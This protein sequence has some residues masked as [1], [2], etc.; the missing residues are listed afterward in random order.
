MEN[1]DQLVRQKSAEGVNS[2][3]RKLGEISFNAQAPVSK[4]ALQASQPPHPL[5][6]QTAPQLTAHLPVGS[7]AA[8][9]GGHLA[10]PRH[11]FGVSRSNSASSN[12]SRQLN[13]VSSLSSIPETT[14]A[15][16]T[17]QLQ[18]RTKAVPR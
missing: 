2:D 16:S 10:V 13:S 5:V 12:G 8:Q 11:R 3:R 18:A 14:P 1:A 9:L 4:P 7:A 17:A 15:R 6:G